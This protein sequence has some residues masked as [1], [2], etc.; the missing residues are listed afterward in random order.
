MKSFTVKFYFLKQ[1]NYSL[2]C[3]RVL[4]AAVYDIAMYI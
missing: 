4:R 2:V 3:A 1:Q